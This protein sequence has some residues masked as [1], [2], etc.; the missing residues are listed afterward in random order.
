M[1]GVTVNV[2]PISGLGIE[3]NR[4]TVLLHDSVTDGKTSPG[5]L[6]GLLGRV[7]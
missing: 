7:K 1:G 4:S 6:A 3:I 5:F 2:V